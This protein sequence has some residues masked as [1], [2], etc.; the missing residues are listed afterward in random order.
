[1]TWILLAWMED[2]RM[3]Q[4]LIAVEVLKPQAVEAAI[5]LL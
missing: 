4:Y 1:M 2:M 3:S 5:T